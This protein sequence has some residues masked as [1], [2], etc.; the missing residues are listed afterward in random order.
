MIVTSRYILNNKASLTM[1]YAVPCVARSGSLINA[2]DVAGGRNGI[3]HPALLN[4]LNTKHA[5]PDGMT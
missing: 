4:K 2:R 1:D 3:R 5:L